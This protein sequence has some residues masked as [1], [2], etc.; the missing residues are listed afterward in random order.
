MWSRVVGSRDGNWLKWSLDLSNRDRVRVNA[1]Y[2]T[3]GLTKVTYMVKVRSHYRNV[4]YM[5][6][7]VWLAGLL[8]VEGTYT[9]DGQVGGHAEL[10][11]H[12]VGAGT[13]LAAVAG[14]WSLRYMLVEQILSV[15]AQVR[16][17]QLKIS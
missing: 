12:L 8:A 2:Y 6:L 16:R 7:S 9:G 13:E 1:Q 14:F 11:R 3:T 5:V 17:L 4:P 15:L 10:D